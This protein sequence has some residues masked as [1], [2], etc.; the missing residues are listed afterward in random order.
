MEEISNYLKLGDAMNEQ[1]PNKL[2]TLKD[3]AHETGFSVTAVSHALK[4]MSD[5]SPS[6]KKIIQDCANRLG[7]IANAS[8]TSL[9]TGKSNTVAIIL[10]DLSS[11]HFSF[12]AKEAER[13]FEQ[14]GYSAF[15]MHSNEQLDI[16]RKSIMAACSRNVDGIILC[17]TQTP[18]S[19]DNINFIQ[20]LNIPCVI[21]G[22]HFDDIDMDCVVSD[23]LKAGQLAAEHIL[24]QKH[25]SILYV[26]TP[27]YNSSSHERLRGFKEVCHQK[28]ITNVK[29]LIYDSDSNYFKEIAENINHSNYTAIVA[30]NDIMAWDIM[31]ELKKIG[32]KVPDD[33]ALI[34]FDN[35]HSLLSLPFELTSISCS[36]NAMTTKAVELLLRR[37]QNPDLPTEKIVLDVTLFDRKTVKEKV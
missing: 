3:I 32:K 7:Y 27:I 21:I 2:P 26:N 10:G 8:A 9:R 15:F 35:L 23:D 31:L 13:Q 29:E 24:S 11:P 33:I 20:G 37:M 28:G 36:K 34:G 12:I 22:R 5:I 30:F 6:T 4:D 1:R 17:P 16:E 25:D 18:Y 19:C 14:K